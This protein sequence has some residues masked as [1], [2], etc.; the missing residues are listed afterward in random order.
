MKQET[1]VHFPVGRVILGFLS[2]FKKSKASSHFEA[3]NSVCLSRCQSDVIPPVQMSGELRLSLGSPHRI[4]TSLHLVT[5]NP[6]LNLSHCKEIRPSFESCLSRYIPLETE[7]TESLSPTYC[8]GKT[9]LEV[10]VEKW[11]TTSVK[12]YNQL[13]SW[14][15]MC[16][17][18]LSSS[19]CAE[20]NIHIDLRRVSQR[21]SV[22]SSRK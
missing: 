5:W 19:C 2:I 4:Q 6:S 3:L 9:P 8:W 17:M 12:S 14:D 20:M 18:E 10:L 22:V 15:D 16:R 7:S 1:E 13:S 11:L 21:I